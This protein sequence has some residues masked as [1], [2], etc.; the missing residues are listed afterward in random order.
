M[1]HFKCFYTGYNHVYTQSN[2]LLTF[3]VLKQHL[4]LLKTQ[5]KANVK[6]IRLDGETSLGNNFMRLAAREGFIIERSATSTQAQNGHTE[7]G[8]RSLVT[9]ARTIR[10]EANLPSNL[11]LELV[12]VVG[13]YL[14]RMLTKGLQWKTLFEAVHGIKPSLG[15]IRLIGCKSFIHQKDVPK[16]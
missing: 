8:G 2:K 5:Y 10:I 15:Y 12:K 7:R 16:L 9:M 3:Q 13:H 14:N 11:W 4:Q 1:S 6:F